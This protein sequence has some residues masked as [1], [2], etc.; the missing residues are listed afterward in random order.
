MKKNKNFKESFFKTIN[1]GIWFFLIGMFIES[2]VLRQYMTYVA[3]IMILSISFIFF[4]WLKK[5]LNIFNINIALKQKIIIFILS[6]L[7]AIIVINLNNVGYI[8]II[9]EFIL[10]AVIWFLVIFISNRQKLKKG[11]N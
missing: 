7:S 3:G 9:I 4:P 1:N 8:N 11:S 5:I 10:V 6:F 2:I